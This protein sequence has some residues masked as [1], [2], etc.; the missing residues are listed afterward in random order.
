MQ[1]DM[2]RHVITRHGGDFGRFRWWFEADK[3]HLD[4]VYAKGSWTTFVRNL[5]R[6]DTYALVWCILTI[7]ALPQVVL[8][9]GAAIFGGQSVLMMMH[10]IQEARAAG[11]RPR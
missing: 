5:T 7:C 9:Y 1:A 10:T 11:R 6:R 4:E 3:G 8:V 2:Y